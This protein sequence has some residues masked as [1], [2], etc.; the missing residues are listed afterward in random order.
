MFYG[1]SLL[2]QEFTSQYSKYSESH[3]VYAWGKN[4]DGELGLENTKNI[5]EP[6]PVKTSIG[7]PRQI[8]SAHSHTGLINGDGLLQMTGSELHNKLMLGLKVTN[9]LKFH[10][11]PAL[12]SIPIKQIA[13][14]AYHTLALADSG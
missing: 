3:L 11:Q 4:E 10:I 14:G 12:Q 9:V 8:S 7:Y 6:R 13:C 1:E 5:K 2:D